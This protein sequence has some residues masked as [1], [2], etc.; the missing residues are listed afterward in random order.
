MDLHSEL[1]KTADGTYERWCKKCSQYITKDLTYKQPAPSDE[2][3][4][5][6]KEYDKNETNLL[7]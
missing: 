3:T 7:R 4:D 1:V 2:D 6:K 5:A